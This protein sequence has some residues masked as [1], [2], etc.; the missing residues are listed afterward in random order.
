M[1]EVGIMERTLEIALDR[2]QNSGASQIHHLKMRVG[3]LSGVVPEALN[4]AFD[5]V[6][7]GTI[8]QNAQFEIESVPARCY[9]SQCQAEFEPKDIIFEC[10]TCHRVSANVISGK[11]LELTSLEIS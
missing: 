1:H 5:V 2:A 8:A 10:P 9:C 3:A 7:E 4:F 11:E 6:T